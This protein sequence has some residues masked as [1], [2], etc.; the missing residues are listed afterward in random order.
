MVLRIAMQL[1]L[2]DLEPCQ[3]VNKTIFIQDHGK[4]KQVVKVSTHTEGKRE[5]KGRQIKFMLKT[6]GWLGS[7][8]RVGMGSMVRKSGIK[9]PG[10]CVCL[11]QNESISV[12][13][14]W[15]AQG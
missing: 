1:P 8:E 15:G 2:W 10:E 4:D 7:D 3:R 14:E 13:L 11:L 6:E 5:V 12:M 9:R